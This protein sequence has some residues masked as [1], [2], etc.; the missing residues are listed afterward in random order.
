[1]LAAKPLTTSGDCGQRWGLAAEFNN[2]DDINL[3]GSRAWP[4]A[5]AFT[6]VETIVAEL[7]RQ[8]YVVYLLKD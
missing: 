1:V 3:R 2:D 8:M 6:V 5:A 7:V 4:G